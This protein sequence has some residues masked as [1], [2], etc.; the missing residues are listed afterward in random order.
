MKAISI[1][2]WRG[3][4]K[5][6][7]SCWRTMGT[8][9]REF[10][11]ITEEKIRAVAWAI[12]RVP[13]LLK[14]DGHFVEIG[15]GP[16]GVGC[17]HFFPQTKATCDLV[18]VDPLPKEVVDAINYP[19]PLERLVESCRENYGQVCALGEQTGLREGFF[20]LAACY[21]VLDHCWIPQNVLKE[22]YR[23]LKPGAYF[24]L[25]CDVR[26]IISVLKYNLYGRWRY[27]RSIGVIAHPHRFFAPQLER[28]VMQAGFEIVQVNYR[29]FGRLKRVFGHAH[30][31]L[32]VGRKPSQP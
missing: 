26:S 22:I 11:R 6:E 27:S 28:L 17:I 1:E 4:Q 5:A 29:R 12:E 31:M 18:G 13:D 24:L 23:I 32:L 7:E 25:G 10:A 3:A 16:M 19:K 8:D 15:I 21:N 14:L 2:R 30:R 9:V 20:S